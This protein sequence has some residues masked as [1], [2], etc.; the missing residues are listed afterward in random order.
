M[1]PDTRLPKQQARAYALP[2][3]DEYLLGYKDRSAVLAAAHAD[4]VCPGG[5][6]MFAPTMVVDGRVVGTWKRA[7]KKSSVAIEAMP[8]AT[9][10]KTARRA[11]DEAAARYAAFIG[12]HAALA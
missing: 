12:L 10:P 11:F 8:F 9:L 7:I 1:A 2:G 4:R 3:F 5:N 6:G